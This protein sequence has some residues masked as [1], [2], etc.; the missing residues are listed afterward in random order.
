M[1][2]ETKYG[3]GK[4]QREQSFSRLQ[5]HIPLK[6]SEGNKHLNYRERDDIREGIEEVEQ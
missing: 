6:V 1:C 4:V 2:K 3:N 5:A